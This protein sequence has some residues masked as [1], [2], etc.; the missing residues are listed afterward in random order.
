MSD[1]VK[2]GQPSKY[3]PEY[4]DMLIDH[5]SEGYSFESFG[6]VIRIGK[7]TMYNWI[8]DHEEWKE[9]KDVAEAMALKYFETAIKASSMDECIDEKILREKFDPKKINVTTM[10][11]FI[12]SRFHSVYSEKNVTVIEGGDKPVQIEKSFNLDNLTLEELEQLE[13]LKA[14][15]EPEITT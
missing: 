1:E 3:K 13:K 8:K 14:K 15:L 9:A 10:Q 11:W 2:L 7:K 6:A 4:C 12:K 5:M